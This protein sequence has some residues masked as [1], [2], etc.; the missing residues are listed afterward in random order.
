[1]ALRTAFLIFPIIHW[2]LL[3]PGPSL[4]PPIAGR[5]YSALD[6]SGASVDAR[7]RKRLGRGPTSTYIMSL[8]RFSFFGRSEAIDVRPD[9]E[10][11][12]I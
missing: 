12:Q 1:M 10:N 6:A 3:S 11:V 8:D 9:F 4:G 5:S 7:E 2:A